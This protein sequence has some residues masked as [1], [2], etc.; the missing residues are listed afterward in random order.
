MKEVAPGDDVAPVP[1]PLEPA[2]P[3]ADRFCDLVLTGGV[4]SGVVYPWA[5]VELARHY[6]FRNI[7]GTSVG[8]MAAALAA[9]AEY[10]RRTG[11]ERPFE[12]LRRAP[13]AL[14]EP[15][16][17]GG[18][19][20]LSLFQTAPRGKRL[21]AL[22]AWFGRGSVEAGAKQ[23]FVHGLRKVGQV[24][25]GPCVA[26]AAL[27]L[28][29]AA[30]VVALVAAVAAGDAWKGACLLALLTVPL[31]ALAGL[32]LALWRDIREGVIGNGLGLCKGGTLVPQSEDDPRPG[33][34][35]WLHE[36]IQ[37]SA[38]LDVND[39]PLT[40]RDLWNAPAH[41]GAEPGQCSEDDPPPRRS[42]N[43]QM[44]TSNVTHG[45]PYRLPLNHETSRL[46][47]RPEDLVDYLPPRVLAALVDAAPRYAVRSNSDPPPGPQTEGFL[48]LPGADLPLAVAARLSL[49]FPL[50][51]A[52]VPLYAIDY[53]APKAHRTLKRCWFSDGGVSSNFPI[54]LFDAAL[55]RWPTFGL[56]LDR[57]DPYREGQDIWL[58]EFHDQ[59]WGDNWNR[60]D[61]AAAAS[62]AEPD[63]ADPLDAA[64]PAHAGKPRPSAG[65]VAAVLL[66]FAGALATS[67]LDWR[68]RTS[69]RLPH[70]RNR[71]ARLL[72][73]RGEGGLNIA[74]PREQILGMAHRYG[75]QAGKAFVAHFADRDGRE[76]DAWR[77]Q[78]WVRLHLLIGGLRERLT[79]LAGAAAS[80][81]RSTPMQRAI[82]AASER[83]PLRDH[84]D[85]RRLDTAQQRSL[86][87]LLRE[88]ERL[89][90]VFA[91]AVAQDFRPVPDPEM[92][93]RAPL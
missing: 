38:G 87:E 37:R 12:A 4:A 81:P 22:W 73:Q 19:R 83:G 13:A 56:W 46:F 33:I 30:L 89:E 47:F 86:Q 17:G 34:S 44:L 78:R 52:A 49:S 25:A 28:A 40:F 61:P 15:L 23:G 69:F 39:R 20:M 8:A 66:G 31:G 18:T 76:S 3:P 80:A 45:R 35:Q 71:V 16:R 60:F 57:R 14:A 59:G 79:G 88:L 32:T 29:L 48:Q 68:D 50:L 64:N 10:G 62:A 1:P 93:L 55:P 9:A 67:A 42:I 43:L 85:G 84:G 36:A 92:R 26:G 90:Q 82:A 53:E 63:A 7:G 24:Y 6:R 41:P 54:H 51:F 27:G 70:V 72:L 75:T 21:I 74:M 11:I 5:I 77:E 2:G 58:P 91:Q 65:K